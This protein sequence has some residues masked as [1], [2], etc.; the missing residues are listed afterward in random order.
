MAAPRLGAIGRFREARR[1][2]W[3][4]GKLSARGCFAG[5]RG[6]V[7]YLGRRRLVSRFRR[8]R[9]H[10]H[11]DLPRYR[12]ES[13]DREAVG[14]TL[15]ASAEAERCQRDS[16]GALAQRTEKNDM[17]QNSHVADDRNSSAPKVHDSSAWGAAPGSAIAQLVVKAPT[18]RHRRCA[19]FR[20]F[21]AG[22]K[23]WLSSSWGVAPG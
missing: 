8:L 1:A 12:Y 14:V 3:P 13:G 4:V 22:G 2:R 16:T 19:L 11:S 7:P 15:P 20:P 10:R 17:R 9:R 5:E 6:D 21:R 18:G 23:V